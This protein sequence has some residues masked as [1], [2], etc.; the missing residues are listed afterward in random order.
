MENKIHIIWHNSLDSTQNE[1]QRRLEELD[2]LSVIAARSQSAGRGQRGNSWLSEPGLNLTASLLV[3]FGRDGIPPL[4]AKNYFRLNMAFSLAVRDYLKCLSVPAS[5]KW[6]NDIYVKGKKICGVLIENVL[7]G[8]EIV[9]SVIGFGL[10]LN[11]TE[12][13]A[14][15][16]ATSVRCVTG[17]ET[18]VEEALVTLSG[19][20]VNAVVEALQEDGRALQTRYETYLFNKG[21]IRRYRELPGGEEFDGILTGITSDGRAIVRTDRGERLFAFKEL[22]YI[23]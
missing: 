1:V 6:P 5:I 7:S 12:F 11:Q 2:N 10:N 14:L 3:R 22:G 17:S 4:P 21:Q 19:M 13:P 23:L 8:T 16:S 15:A 9:S 20:I 18:N